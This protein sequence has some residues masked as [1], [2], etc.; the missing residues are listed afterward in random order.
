M[1]TN[2][3][4]SNPLHTQT[5]SAVGGGGRV[6]AF[7]SSK[8]PADNAVWGQSVVMN[9]FIV[10]IIVAASRGDA[11]RASMHLLVRLRCHCSLDHQYDCVQFYWNQ[12]ND[13]TKKTTFNMAAPR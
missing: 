2:D 12:T 8:P 5:R 4:L 1:W 11:V 10:I 3:R 6:H 7:Q 13:V 9:L